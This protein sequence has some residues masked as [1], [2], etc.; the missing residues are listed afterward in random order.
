MDIDEEVKN[1]DSPNKNNKSTIP[2][3]EHDL[4]NYLLNEA[5]ENLVIMTRTKD[6]EIL[7]KI[8]GKVQQWLETVDKID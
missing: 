7:S 3:D 2:K 4:L 1:D 8:K 6:Y 5:Q